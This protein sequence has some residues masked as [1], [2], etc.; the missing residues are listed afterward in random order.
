MGLQYDEVYIGT[1]EERAAK[2]HGD[3]ENKLTEGTIV[4]YGGVGTHD[5]SQRFLN[6]A[7]E[8]AMYSYRREKCLANIKDLR[9]QVKEAETQE[10]KEAFTHALKLEIAAL[11]RVNSEEMNSTSFRKSTL[12][13]V[14]E[15][16]SPSE[17]SDVEAQE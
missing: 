2:G 13:L 11:G 10:E 16:P 14:D 5:V 15:G 3:A 12:D 1:P 8:D 4:A 17:E 6:L 7:K 9:E